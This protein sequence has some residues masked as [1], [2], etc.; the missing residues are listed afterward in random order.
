MVSTLKF[1]FEFSAEK[2]KNDLRQ[3][4]EDEWTP[5]FNQQYYLGDWSGIAFRA[6]KNARIPL[7]PDPANTEG[8]EFTPMLAR[9]AYLPEVLASFHCEMEA[10]RFLKLGAGSKILEHRDYQLGFEDGVVRIHIP[11]ETNPQ[12]T[13]YLD[14]KLLSMREGEAWYLDFNLP[15]H[16]ENEGTTPRVHL[17]LDCLLND[18][19]SEFFN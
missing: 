15:H 8:F 14:G 11:V 13:F 5:H 4:N 3:F 17:V 9:C 6:T 1:P 18:W 16:V 7:Y 2:L 12:V 19:L 10:V